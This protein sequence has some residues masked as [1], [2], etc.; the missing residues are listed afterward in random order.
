[1]RE[2]IS[3][4]AE[5]ILFG[6]GMIG[7]IVGVLLMLQLNLADFMQGIFFLGAALSTLIIQ[8]FLTRLRRIEEAIRDIPSAIAPNKTFTH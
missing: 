1:M 4:A 5:N 8:V 2:F 3:N 6:I 7:L